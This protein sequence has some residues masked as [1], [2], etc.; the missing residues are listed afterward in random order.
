MNGTAYMEKIS[1]L[2]GR[3]VVNSLQAQVPDEI[4]DLDLTFQQLHALIYAGQHE[5]CSIGDIASGLAVTHPAAVKLIERLIRKGL[6]R[7]S[8]DSQ[9]RRVSCVSLTEIG[10]RIVKAVQERRTETIR[11]ALE[12]MTA[13]EQSGLV[14]GLEELLA[15][16]LETENLVESTCLRCGIAHDKSCVVNRAH[17]A[18]TGSG[19]ERT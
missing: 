16:S 2:F 18:L 13:E 14:K 6:V 4:K 12:K 11:R 17:V 5:A 19:I 3:I 15:A 9:D 8:E 7:K 1:N 10:R